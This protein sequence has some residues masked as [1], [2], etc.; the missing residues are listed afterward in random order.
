M[1]TRRSGR[2]RSPSRSNGPVRIYV[3]ATPKR[4]F[5]SA[6]DW[7]GWSRGGR[8]EEAALESLVAYGP[9]YARVAKRARIRFRAPADTSELE[10]V[11]RLQ[12]GPSTD[13]GVP[14]LPASGDALPVD[15]AEA[16]RL[17][18]LSQACWDTF[19][20]IAASA[21][22]VELRKGPRGGGRDLGKITGHVFEAESSYL[23][24]FGVKRL[25]FDIAEEAAAW[26]ALRQAEVEAFGVRARG[27]PLADAN[28]V[29]K[30]WSPRYFVRRVAWH[31]MDHAW[32]I[33]DR[34][35]PDQDER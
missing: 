6:I 2:T 33:E 3:E 8:T 32:E 27:E 5:A 20:A 29:K 18:A 21:V 9:R 7:P 24:Q 10:V 17:V 4:A 14:S 13:F 19:D 23:V 34:M 30:P 11:E 25:R 35:M 31:V 12:G 28:R 16:R 26:P 15:P 1:N 22:G